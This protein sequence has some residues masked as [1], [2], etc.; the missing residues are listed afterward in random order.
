MMPSIS[1]K[2][3]QLTPLPLFE[4]QLLNCR[5]MTGLAHSTT[6]LSGFCKFLTEQFQSQC[7][8]LA[9]VRTLGFGWRARDMSQNTSLM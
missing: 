5:T 9:T 8:L 6:S 4:R 1:R 7:T 3:R 2:L